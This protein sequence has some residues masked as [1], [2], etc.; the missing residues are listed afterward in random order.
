MFWNGNVA[1]ILYSAEKHRTGQRMAC[2]NS[3]IPMWEKAHSQKFRSIWRAAA[4]ARND[5]KPM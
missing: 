2:V 5:R 4:P 1:S 3:P